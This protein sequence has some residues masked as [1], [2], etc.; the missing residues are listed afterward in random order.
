[1]CPNERE[2]FRRNFVEARAFAAARRTLRS[3]SVRLRKRRAKIDV[4]VEGQPTLRAKIG[5]I[6]RKNLSAGGELA[7]DVQR[8]NYCGAAV[9]QPKG[10]DLREYCGPFANPG[11]CHSSHPIHVDD[12]L[13]RPRR[14]N[15][16]EIYTLVQRP[17]DLNAAI[18]AGKGGRN[19]M[20]GRQSLHCRPLKRCKQAAACALPKGQAASRSE[21]G[22]QR[23]GPKTPRTR[24]RNDAA[25]V[26]AVAATRRSVA[27]DSSCP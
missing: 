20:P 3:R 11:R 12:A 13:R 16:S 5:G 7:D 14:K 26:P 10:R 25:G 2:I 17:L 4:Y 27:A 15:R 9:E 6:D 22:R 8:R 23:H 18:L 1:M 24:E 21:P 19:S